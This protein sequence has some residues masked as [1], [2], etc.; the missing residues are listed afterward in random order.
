MTVEV[1]FYFNVFRGIKYDVIYKKESNIFFSCRLIIIFDC[2]NTNEKRR[3]NTIRDYS[4]F[5][6]A[7]PFVRYSLVVVILILRAIDFLQVDINLIWFRNLSSSN[8]FLSFSV[9]NTFQVFLCMLSFK[10]LIKQGRFQDCLKLL[11][12]LCILW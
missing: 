2:K 3:E 11:W 9:W 1:T 4:I 7:F 8:D 10:F 5:K 12:L 6:W